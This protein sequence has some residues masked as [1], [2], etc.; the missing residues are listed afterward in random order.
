MAFPSLRP[1]RR[2]LWSTAAFATAA[3]AAGCAG[4]AGPNTASDADNDPLE[5]LNRQIFAFNQ[6]ADRA[7]IKPVAKGYRDA[8]PEPVRDRIRLLID[9][10]HEPLIAANDL[11][12]GRAGASATTL[13]R[14]LI[15][16][17]VGFFGFFDRAAEM[18]ML[19]QSG[20][21][22][23]TLYTWGVGE[24]A[25]IVIPI[26]GPSN[27]RDGI[28]LGV[29]GYAS[30]I[31]HVGSSEVRLGTVLGI[32]VTDGIDLRSRHIESLDQL[33]A[34]S[35]D[36]YAF[37][38]SISQQSRRAMLRRARGLP[39]TDDLSDP[40]ASQG[41]PVATPSAPAGPATST[42]TAPASEGDAPKK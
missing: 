19:R 24:G 27:I 32:G 35:L 22:G 13:G 11:L 6:A 18:G 9:N 21:F 42:P 31:G 1:L 5:P 40:G 36:F 16:S 7:V 17:T 12:Q 3:V 4:T 28:G 20:D 10:L 25:Y 26:L 2:T 8:L 30:P 39:E 33:E 29:D 14:F 34:G 38:R 15:N 37:L 23:Q 41:D